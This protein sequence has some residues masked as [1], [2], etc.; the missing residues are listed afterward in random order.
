MCGRGNGAMATYPVFLDSR[1]AYFGQGRP[2]H[3]LLLAPLGRGTVFSHLLER[4]QP[5]SREEPTILPAF[6]P[7]AEYEQ[8]VRAAT[9]RDLTVMEHDRFE[10]LTY[11]REPSDWLLLL[12]VAS[13]PADACNLA[14][15]L[16]TAPATMPATHL[17]SVTNGT[18]AA[19]ECVHLDTAGCVRRIQRYYEGVTWRNTCGITCSLVSVAAARTAGV[20]SLTCLSDFRQALTQRRVPARDLCLPA[21]AV[22]LRTEH[23]LLRLTEG[24]V[25]ETT[26]GTALPMR[27]AAE[28]VYIGRDC[29]IHPSARLLGQVLIQ[30]RVVVEAGAR[31]IGPALLGV[32]AR[33]GRGAAVAH[34]LI[35][36]RTNVEA[37]AVVRGRVFC[38]G[39]AATPAAS[40]L[41]LSLRLPTLVGPSGRRGRRWGYAHVKRGL[42]F[43]VAL[44]GLVALAPLFA[45]VA[46]IVKLS[47]RGPVCFGHGREGRE[48]REFCCCKFR[49]MV[50][51]ADAQQ[52]KLY[53]QNAVDGPQF[54]LEHDPRITRVGHWL[55]K[56][57]IDELPQLINVLR[58]QMSLIGPRPSPFRENQ[59]C[60]PWRQARLSVRPGITGLWQLCR[61]ERDAGDFHQWIYYDILYVR[62]MSF[63]LDLK[64]LLATLATFGGRWSVP[65]T[66]MIPD[67]K[68][69]QERELSS[70]WRPFPIL[71]GTARRA[72][73]AAP[74]FGSA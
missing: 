39:T 33:V 38:G 10:E 31:I 46:V 45:V 74:R 15:A 50:V 43:V 3:S 42:D 67:H 32:E 48:G 66:W 14:D 73:S 18:C 25:C 57:N 69:Y 22:D 61:H 6:D 56:T 41:N 35:M 5:I 36:P 11:N 72:T 28:N 51:G 60:V 53:Q 21:G 71:D 52:R 55:R 1:P 8:A 70:N 59:I 2:E 19:Q 68:P 37:E 63:W 54:K 44:L 23:G 62:N 7:G 30:D 64:I 27:H 13:Y 47:S 29:E 17:V 40:T 49:T 9:K 34:S 16:K 58:G 12:D 26:L 65:I 4:V 24:M 20:M